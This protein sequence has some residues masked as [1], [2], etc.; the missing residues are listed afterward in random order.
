MVKRSM[1]TVALR[2]EASIN[3]EIFWRFGHTE[4]DNL[5]EKPL[6]D[7]AMLGFLRIELFTAVVSDVMDKIDLTQTIP[8]TLRAAGVILDG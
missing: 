7:S 4:K 6:T 8:T 3:N 1:S 2:F 5:M